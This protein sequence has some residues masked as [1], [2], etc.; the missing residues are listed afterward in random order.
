MTNKYVL[1]FG[2]VSVCGVGIKSPSDGN[3]NFLPVF[4]SGSCADKGAKQYMEDE[5]MCIDDLVV[6]L[7]A[8]ADASASFVFS[9]AFYGV[10]YL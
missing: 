3:S 9:G 7:G 5:H 10:R 2:Q 8:G 6:E 4:R 1:N